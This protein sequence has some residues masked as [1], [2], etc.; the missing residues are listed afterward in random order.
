MMSHFLSQ[1]LVGVLL[2][3]LVSLGPQ[4]LVQGAAF[5]TKNSRV[6]VSTPVSNYPKRLVGDVMS[7]NPI[8]LT[9]DMS[10]HDAM[11]TLLQNGASGA[12]V[13]K[14][15]TT[16]DGKHKKKR[17]VGIVSSF[18]FLQQ[19]AFEGAL[20]PVE[21]TEQNVYKYV[22]AARK[23]CGQVVEDVMNDNV[24]TV[25]P[26][27]PMR[28][29]AEIMTQH[30]LHRLAVVPKGDDELVGLLTA[31]HVMKDLMHIYQRLPP[32]SDDDTT[33]SDG[34]TLNP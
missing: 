33:T 27:T 16:N 20:L 9:P 19:E 12:P 29:A 21:G 17:L 24:L 34:N 4:T 7:T 11:A 26:E 23:I 22:H 31:E 15:E 3:L 25:T 1:F 10:V 32:A 14:T 13:I 28:E 5:S 30:N 8:C 6:F 2:L 18:D